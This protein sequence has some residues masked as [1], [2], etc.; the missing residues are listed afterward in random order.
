MF[1]RLRTNA[2]FFYWFNSATGLEKIAL[3]LKDAAK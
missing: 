1:E 3:A 2:A